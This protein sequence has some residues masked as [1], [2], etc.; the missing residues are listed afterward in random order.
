MR[1]PAVALPHALLAVRK[2]LGAT[3]VTRVATIEALVAK[4][5]KRFDRLF[6]RGEACAAEPDEFEAAC[7]EAVEQLRLVGN[8]PPT[9]IAARDV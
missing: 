4:D 5:I 3:D 8:D 1:L 6:L 2:E 7:F 9:D